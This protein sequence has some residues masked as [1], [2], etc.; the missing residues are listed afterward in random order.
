MK[1]KVLLT[2]KG[3]QVVDGETDSTEL[4]TTGFMTV[5]NGKYYLT[6]DE[7]DATGF[8]GCKTVIKI[9]NDNRISMQRY[10]TYQSLLIMEKGCRHQCLYGT[11]M[12]E[13]TIG[14]YTHLLETNLKDDGGEI[15]ALDVNTAL[16]SEN[17]IDITV[18]LI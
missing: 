1:Q 18:K 2:I 15:H 8:G 5:Q 4:Q 16:V 7:T 10:G 9:E 3:A 13:L 12:G 14:V 17:R 6:Y 11:Q